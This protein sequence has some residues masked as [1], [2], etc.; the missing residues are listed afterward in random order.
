MKMLL[1]LLAFLKLISCHQQRNY[2]AK[3]C[4]KLF[5]VHF[6]RIAYGAGKFWQSKAKL[7]CK[8]Q[9]GDYIQFI[10]KASD[11]VHSCQHIFSC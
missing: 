1:L 6:W 9:K 11:T 10:G 7:P 3:S 5:S 8:Y 2:K 4:P